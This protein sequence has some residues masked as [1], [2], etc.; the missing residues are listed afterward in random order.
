MTSM[1][2]AKLNPVA[3]VRFKN[4]RGVMG[5]VLEKRSEEGKPLARFE[6]ANPSCKRTHDRASSDWHQVSRCRF[7][8]AKRVRS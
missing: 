4:P 7:C 5:V 3:G 6:C 8:V 1:A 2:K